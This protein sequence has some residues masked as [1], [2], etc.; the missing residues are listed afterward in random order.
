MKDLSNLERRIDEDFISIMEDFL[1]VDHDFAV[2]LHGD[3]YRNNVMFKYKNQHGKEVPVDLRM[4]DFQ[5]ARFA[6]IA[7]DLSIFI[8]TY[9]P[10]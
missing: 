2:I 4:F 1:R 6:T 10:L 7:I 9:T 5:E 3:Y 8:C